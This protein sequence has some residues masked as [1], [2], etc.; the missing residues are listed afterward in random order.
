M[1]LDSQVAPRGQLQRWIH[2]WHS[3]D[4]FIYADPDHPSFDY[5]PPMGGA[6]S[7]GSCSRGSWPV[8][9]HYTGVGKSESDDTPALYVMPDTWWT[10]HSIPFVGSTSGLAWTGPNCMCERYSRDACPPPPPPAPFVYVAT[11][12]SWADAR[13]DCQ[14]RGGELASIHNQAENAQAFNLTAGQTVWLGLTEEA[15]NATECANTCVGNPTYAFDGDCDDGGPGSEYDECSFGTDC[16]DCDSRG[17][18]SIGADGHDHGGRRMTEESSSSSSSSSSSTWGNLLVWLGL[19]VGADGHDY[20][21]RRRTE[22]SSSSS[23]SSSSIPTWR[24]TYDGHRNSN[25]NTMCGYTAADQAT[26]AICKDPADASFAG[27]R[28]CDDNGGS[29][30]SCD[31]NCQTHSYAEAETRCAALGMRVCTSSEVHN[32]FPVGCGSGCRI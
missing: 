1:A 3:D 26:T 5:S 31:N 9:V 14:G 22:E 20:G 16:F 4:D 19:T 23:S 32:T 18:A 15:A 6:C 2:S 24:I 21:G 27:T 30:S 10:T 13:Q 8:Y 11:P 28:C 29:S 12:R 7:Q 25:S 17:D